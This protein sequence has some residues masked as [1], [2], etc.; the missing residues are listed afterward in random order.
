MPIPV[1]PAAAANDDLPLAT[2]LHRQSEALL[3]RAHERNM[4]NAALAGR[5]AGKAEM[6]LTYLEHGLTEEAIRVLRG[7]KALFDGAA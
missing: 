1:N 2:V 5:L 4:A 3:A 7:A 6:A